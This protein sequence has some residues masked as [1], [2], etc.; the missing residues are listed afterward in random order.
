MLIRLVRLAGMLFLAVM[1]PGVAAAYD[2][3]DPSFSAN[4]A[5][6]LFVN[7]GYQ[8]DQLA[9]W[10]WMNPPVSTFRLRDVA[11]ERVLL[12]QVYPDVAQ[13]QRGSARMVEGYAASTW[14]NNVALFE[15]DA[16]DYQRVQ[17]AALARSV[18]MLRPDWS[19]ANVPLERVDAEYTGL[20]LDAMELKST[21]AAVP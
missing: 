11:R 1:W 3:A 14:I 10:D 5:H 16:D 12:V 6:A 15:A 8:V 2:L 19:S 21:N 18:G 17:T 13:A 7:A 9:A 4:E 20:V